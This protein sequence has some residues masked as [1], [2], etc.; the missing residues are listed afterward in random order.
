LCWT[1]TT[2]RG[3]SIDLFFAHKGH[4]IASDRSRN[5]QDSRAGYSRGDRPELD[6]DARPVAELD[7]VSG[8]HAHSAVESA[9]LAVAIRPDDGRTKAHGGGEPT[10]RHLDVGLCAD[11]PVLHRHRMHL[12]LF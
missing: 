3:H 4:S 9:E 7:S 5:I 11:A 12:S 2:V 1:S 6:L 10:A 8:T